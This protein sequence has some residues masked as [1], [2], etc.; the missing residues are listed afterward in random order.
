MKRLNT[1]MCTM[2]YVVGIFFSSQAYADL[3]AG[4]K[5]P[6]FTL[7]NQ[8][9]DSISLSDYRDQW[10]VLYFY[11]KNDTPGCTTEACSFRD[12]INTLIKQKAVILGISIDSMESHKKFSEKYKLPFSLLADPKAM[13][14]DRYNAMLNLG[15]FKLAKRHSFIINPQGM[16]AK[17]YRDVDPDTHVQEVLK[18]LTDL[19]KSAARK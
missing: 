6:E 9:G 18:D 13:I 7:I 11:P 17:A 1:W 19:K 15:L 10:I 12:N 5:A 3:Q 2:L 16:I 14:A 4:D 8:H